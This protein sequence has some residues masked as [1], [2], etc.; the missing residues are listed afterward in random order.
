MK[1]YTDALIEGYTPK[2]RRRLKEST[3][4][5]DHRLQNELFSLVVS[6]LAPEKKKAIKKTGGAGDYKL[7]VYNNG[8]PY[9]HDN[10]EYDY[11]EFEK[12]ESDVTDG[13][14]AYTYSE[15]LAA[16]QALADGIIE[17]GEFGEEGFL[18]E[19][20]YPPIVPFDSDECGGGIVIFDP[21][22]SKI[23]EYLITAARN[24]DYEET[25]RFDVLTKI[26][27]QGGTTGN[28]TI[29]LKEPFD[30]RFPSDYSASDIADELIDF[31]LTAD[32]ADALTMRP[33]PD[34]KCEISFMVGSNRYHIYSP[35]IAVA[36]KMLYETVGL[37]DGKSYPQKFET[38]GDESPAPRDFEAGL[39]ICITLPSGTVSGRPSFT[40]NP[41]MCAE[42]V[43]PKNPDADLG[44]WIVTGSID[45]AI[46]KP[47]DLA[48]DLIQQ[49]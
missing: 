15:N 10:P 45:A 25:V 8:Q 37:E 14:E 2:R 30:P 18:G 38:V 16:L 44:K 43:L 21:N 19:V 7:W 28:R 41:A 27:R 11:D 24:D 31:W 5:E 48:P 9:Y 32:E 49:G 6:G 42:T 33:K 1:D 35:D 20:A 36:K 13:S 47:I 46:G 22:G 4:E 12:D 3:S 29:N 23:E 40:G 39:K 26:A 17:S 34:S